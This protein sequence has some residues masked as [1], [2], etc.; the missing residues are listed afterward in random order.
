MIK[1]F[2]TVRNR[3]AITKKC[4]EALKRHTNSKYHLY[5]YNNSTNYLIDEHFEY[6][7]D[8]HKKGEIA[9]VTFNTDT[10]T[11]NA[12]SKAVTCNM[13]GLAHEQDPNKDKFSFLLML[14]ND[15]IMMPDWDKYVLMGWNYIKKNNLKHV[16]VIG[17]LPGGI[18]QKQPHGKTD[19]FSVK[20]GKLGGSGLWCVRSNFFRDVGFLNIKQL[21][22]HDKRHDQNYW[23]LMEQASGGKPYIMGVG[24][25]LGVH[26]GRIAGSVCNRLTRNRGNPKKSELIKFPEAEQNI[27]SKSFDE[28]FQG[29][30]KDERLA[31]DW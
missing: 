11:F 4:I 30:I 14:D 9:Q 22:G 5:V 19:Q 8:L 31:K 28:F 13:F 29:I 6:F 24:V 20:L 10:S 17:Q 27:E 12:F 25:K 21:V 16:K 26:C 15:I 23:R 2:L 1:I 3:L 7:R 18:K